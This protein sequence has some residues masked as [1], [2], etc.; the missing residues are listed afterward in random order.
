MSTQWIVLFDDNGFDTIIPW[1]DIAEEGM[2][3]V[4]SGA[5][6][7]KWHGN[8]LVNNLLIRARFNTQRNA[9]VW[10]F[11]TAEDIDVELMNSSCD[12]NSKNMK[13]L[14]RK[15]GEKLF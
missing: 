7:A 5:E 3:Q 14:I 11:N 10:G 13:K 2:L 15:H 4:L 6:S 8:S 12:K 1:S 9:E